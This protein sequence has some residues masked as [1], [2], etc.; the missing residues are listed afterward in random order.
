M[1]KSVK[2]SFIAIAVAMGLLCTASVTYLAVTSYQD[3]A[4]AMAA[5][6]QAQFDAAQRQWKEEACDYGADVAVNMVAYR[7][8]GM[9]S[10]S[11]GITAQAVG[12]PEKGDHSGKMLGVFLAT[13][14]D[15]VRY[16]Y[17]DNA[18]GQ[19]DTRRFA[20]SHCRT[21]IFEPT[22]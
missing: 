4:K 16:V 21:K 7:N 6:K 19:E 12:K 14:D 9:P 13:D 22:S 8:Q 2:V 10:Y 20:L 11:A 1:K 5:E 17:G 15:V 18:P 3:R